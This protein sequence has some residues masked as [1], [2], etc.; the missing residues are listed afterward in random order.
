MR[1]TLSPIVLVASLALATA[2]QAAPHVESAWS[3]PAAQGAA[4]AGF[5]LV[6]NPD[7]RA[8]AL[9]GAEAAIARETQIHRTTVTDGVARMQRQTAA[10]IPAGGRLIFAPGG[11]HLMF[12]G[13][14]R[15]LKVGE[16]FPVTLVFSSGARVKTDF[17]VGVTPPA[18]GGHDHKH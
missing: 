1:H 10:A 17:V 13:L 3:R 7:P 6:H 18:G 2:A 11:Y 16:R 8:D 15:P 9:V 5:M 14:S 12:M 4:G